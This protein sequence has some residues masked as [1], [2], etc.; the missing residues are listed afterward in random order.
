MHV[1][2]YT[3]WGCQHSISLN[4]ESQICI[5]QHSIMPLVLCHLNCA[6]LWLKCKL[7]TLYIYVYCIHIILIG[8]TEMLRKGGQRD[9]WCQ[10]ATKSFQWGESRCLSSSLEPFRQSHAALPLLVLLSWHQNHA[11]LPQP[12][13]ACLWPPG[14]NDFKTQF[15]TKICPNFTFLSLFSCSQFKEGMERGTPGTWSCRLNFISLLALARSHSTTIR[16]PNCNI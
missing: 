5:S 15:F 10:M 4:K 9:R 14:T 8:I 13:L 6:I 7:P 16:P 2:S 1:G 11:P 3:V 12:L